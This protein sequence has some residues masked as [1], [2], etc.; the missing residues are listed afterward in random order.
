MAFPLF[1]MGSCCCRCNDCH[2]CAESLT[3]LN[4]LDMWKMPNIVAY[5]KLAADGQAGCA[6]CARLPARLTR[7]GN[8]VVSAT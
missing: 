5:I 4:T 3:V 8:R 6:A 1:M 7:S 2:A